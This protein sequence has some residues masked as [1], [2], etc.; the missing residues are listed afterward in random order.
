MRDDKYRAAAL[1]WAD[2]FCRAHLAN[3]MCGRGGKHSHH[4]TESECAIATRGAG[5]SA[6]R[7]SNTPLVA[8]AQ[9][10]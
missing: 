1:G 10:H 9:V 3:L 8:R 7:A 5:A 2:F 6:R 4:P